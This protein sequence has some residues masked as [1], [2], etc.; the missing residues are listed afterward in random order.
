MKELR[1]SPVT[2]DL[3]MKPL[4]CLS[5]HANASSVLQINILCPPLVL[6]ICKSHLSCTFLI[7]ANWVQLRYI[8]TYL[9]TGLSINKNQ[10]CHTFQNVDSHL[11]F[12]SAKI[13]HLIWRICK[14]KI[15]TYSAF[16]SIKILQGHLFARHLRNHLAVYFLPNAIHCVN[17][18]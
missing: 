8:T 9:I 10:Q 16:T 18:R 3:T 4:M 15:H 13:N 6:H 12:H 7:L 1:S 5:T 2:W 11:W 14:A 17:V